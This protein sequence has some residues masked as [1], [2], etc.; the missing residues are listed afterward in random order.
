MRPLGAMEGR[1]HGRGW[2]GVGDAG[3]CR[4]RARRHV[5]TSGVPAILC[6]E[7]QKSEREKPHCGETKQHE[8]NPMQPASRRG[9][10]SCTDAAQTH[11]TTTTATNSAAYTCL[12]MTSALALQ[13]Q[14]RSANPAPAR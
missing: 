7:L 9:S 1:R 12:I 11:R 3:G 14:D 5:S 10:H 4:A 8:P 13:S 6:L 2:D